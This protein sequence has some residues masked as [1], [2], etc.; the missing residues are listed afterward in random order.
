VQPPNIDAQAWFAQAWLFFVVFL[1]PL[2]INLFPQPLKPPFLFLMQ[3]AK[4]DLP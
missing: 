2:K 3:V 1:Q 4:I